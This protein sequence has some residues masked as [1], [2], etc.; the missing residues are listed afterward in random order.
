MIMEDKAKAIKMWIPCVRML[1]VNTV[2]HISMNNNNNIYG[3][4]D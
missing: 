4:I 2:K 3:N 1:F